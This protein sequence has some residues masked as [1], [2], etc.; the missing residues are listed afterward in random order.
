M[1][2]EIRSLLRAAAPPIRNLLARALR[3]PRRLPWIDAQL[4]RTADFALDC[5]TVRSNLSSRHDHELPR[6]QAGLMRT[7]LSTCAVCA[8]V[9]ASLRSTIDLLRELPRK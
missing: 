6:W 7:H 4:R 5:K 3:G 8:P 1:A 9:D 2:S